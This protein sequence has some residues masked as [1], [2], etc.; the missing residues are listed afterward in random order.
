MFILWLVLV[1]LSAASGEP[2]HFDLR[3][4]RMLTMA[5][6]I[7]HAATVHA[8]HNLTR[9][10]LRAALVSIAWYESHLRRSIHDGDCAA[11]ECDQGRAFGP[12]QAWPLWFRPGKPTSGMGLKE[13]TRC[14]LAAAKAYADGHRRCA[15]TTGAHSAYLT[16]HSCDHP[17]ARTRLRL[18]RRLLLVL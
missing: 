13:T 2:E 11:H 9:S 8:T 1:V 10:E 18:H 5:Q 14:A 12:W 4:R 7:D 6:A 15:S 16:G 3:A 17:R